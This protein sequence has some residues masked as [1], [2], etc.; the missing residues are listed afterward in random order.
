MISFKPFF[1]Y[2]AEKK[3]PISQCAK[4]CDVPMYSL[5]AMKEGKVNIKILNR[6]CCVLGLNIKDIMRYEDVDN[7]N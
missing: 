6:L 5:R 4:M 1:G 7:E 3:I 2:L